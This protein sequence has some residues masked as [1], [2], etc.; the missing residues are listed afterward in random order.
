MTDPIREIAMSNER[1]P[2]RSLNRASVETAY[3]KHV[4]SKAEPTA[5]STDFQGG[6]RFAMRLMERIGHRI[7][8]KELFDTLSDLAMGVLTINT[9]GVQSI[10]GNKSQ[11][12]RMLQ[13]IDEESRAR[14]ALRRPKILSG[15]PVEKAVAYS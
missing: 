1:L 13:V 12:L 6:F 10:Q 2:E 8:T 15:T 4:C 5:E 14:E 9:S 3:E 11:A 7:D